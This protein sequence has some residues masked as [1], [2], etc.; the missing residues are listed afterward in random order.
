[1]LSY[2]G[3]QAAWL[4]LVELLHGK[5]MDLNIV[6]EFS[7]HTAHHLSVLHQSPTS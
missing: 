7:L 2:M 5:D 6:A 1:M 4:R 3:N